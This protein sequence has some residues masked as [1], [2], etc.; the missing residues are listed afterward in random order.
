MKYTEIRNL[1]GMV[2]NLF[3]GLVGI[4][5]YIRIRNLEVGIVFT[6]L[7]L[8]DWDFKV[9]WNKKFGGKGAF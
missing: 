7:Y 4:L 9:Y 1:T 2:F 5:K 6:N 8:Y 3:I